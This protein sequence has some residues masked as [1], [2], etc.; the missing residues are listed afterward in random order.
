[1]NY[2]PR[3]NI[4]GGQPDYREVTGRT[5]H[6][7]NINQS[8][9]IG[10]VTYEAQTPAVISELNYLAECVNELEQ[11]LSMLYSRL[12]PVLLPLQPQAETKQNAEMLCPLADGIRA[13]RFGITELSAAAHDVHKAL[14]L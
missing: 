4:S 3:H 13:I 11:T 9:T 1:M 10:E 2:E 7:F 8:A 6:D 12:N 14:Q 5:T